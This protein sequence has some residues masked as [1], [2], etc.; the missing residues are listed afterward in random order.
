MISENEEWNEIIEESYGGSLK[1][2][3]RVFRQ[4]NIS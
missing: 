1:K 2:I 3:T 4:R